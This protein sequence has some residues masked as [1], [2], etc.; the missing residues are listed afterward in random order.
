MVCHKPKC[1]LFSVFFLSKEHYFKV[2]NNGS[3][4]MINGLQVDNFLIIQW[5]WLALSYKMVHWIFIESARQK[6]S[7]NHTSAT[8]RVAFFVDRGKA[9]FIQEHG[10]KLSIECDKFF[11]LFP[12]FFC[13]F[14]SAFFL[15]FCWHKCDHVTALDKIIYVFW[16]W[17]IL[18]IHLYSVIH[19]AHR[20][21]TVLSLTIFFPFFHLTPHLSSPLFSSHSFFLRFTICENEYNYN[22]IKCN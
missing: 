4:P 22:F 9:I 17:W 15:I 12:L 20:T 1:I 6:P 11:F 13:R 2:T 16:H 21:I 18:P 19:D 10:L 14:A 3:T 5:I 7:R 8:S